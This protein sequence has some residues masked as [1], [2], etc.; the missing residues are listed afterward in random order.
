MFE[1]FKNGIG[2]TLEGGINGEM[3]HF[4]LLSNAQAP[5]KWHD[6]IIHSKFSKNDDGFFKVWVNNAL[7]VN[8]KGATM[9]AKDVV[10]K[11]GIY[12]TGISRYANQKNLKGLKKCVL[13]NESHY[14]GKQNNWEE[15]AIEAFTDNWEINHDWSKILYEKCNG[16]YDEIE[17]PNDVVYYD[18][19][20]RADS[21]E[22]LGS[23]HE[24]SKLSNY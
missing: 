9:K 14:F 8:Y 1:Q 22:E 12:R 6:I 17:L 20:R 16:Y 2:V 21:C 15:H 10:H 4:N 7:K 19:I 5:G 11:F 3:A 24:C 23:L 13:E 18:E